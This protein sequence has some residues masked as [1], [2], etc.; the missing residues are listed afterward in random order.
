M[1]KSLILPPS[2]EPVLDYDMLP[3]IVDQVMSYL[4]VPTAITARATCRRYR[5]R[6]DQQLFEHILVHID[7]GVKGEVDL[8]SPYQPFHRL[9]CLP[10]DRDPPPPYDHN[11]GEVVVDA[12]DERKELEEYEAT[13]FTPRGRSRQRQLALTRVFDWRTTTYASA[14]TL[15][16]LKKDLQA[17]NTFRGCGPLEFYLPQYFMSVDL[18]IS[19]ADARPADGDRVDVEVDVPMGT[20]RHH[21]HIIYDNSLAA[22]GHVL[23][24]VV[25]YHGPVQELVVVMEPSSRIMENDSAVD[26]ADAMPPVR[27]H[28]QT[29]DDGSALGWIVKHLP[30]ELCKGGGR[31]VFVGLERVVP[32]LLNLPSYLKGVPVVDAVRRWI[33]DTV[34][35]YV[36]RRVQLDLEPEDYSPWGQKE[37]RSRL[38]FMTLEEWTA[39]HP[40]D[41]I[42]TNKPEYEAR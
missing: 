12:E 10:Y 14:N 2:S 33:D 21:L 9:P 13:L 4:D 7:S 35:E 26:C 19:W 42:L 38:S 29:R 32:S 1:L 15:I 30:H 34:Q 36:Q 17:V 28:D 6:V 25:S 37:Q 11:E 39:S 18:G 41:S 31:A 3:H 22:L 23:T 16:R 40:A 8:L 20:K 27:V 24:E 5:D